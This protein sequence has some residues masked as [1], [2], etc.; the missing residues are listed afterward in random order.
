V[1]GE[2]YRLWAAKWYPCRLDLGCPISWHGGRISKATGSYIPY[3]YYNLTIIMYLKVG[4][5]HEWLVKH[6]EEFQRLADQGNQDFVGLIR[7]LSERE[8]FKDI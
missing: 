5:E 3:S 2:N 7:E 1:L 6:K 4:E 8:D